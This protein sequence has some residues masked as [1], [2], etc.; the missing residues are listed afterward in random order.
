[1][2]HL[3]AVT[4]NHNSKHYDHLFLFIVDALRLDYLK[5]MKE[6]ENDVNG[7]NSP[8]N[9]FQFLHQLLTENSSQSDLF[10]FRADPPTVTSQRLK[11]LTTGSLPTFIDIAL[12]INS[13]S[14]KEDNLILQFQKLQKP[15]EVYGDDT[16]KLL[17]P[18][19]FSEYAMF[20]SFN[21]RDLSTVDEGILKKLGDFSSIKEGN[22]SLFVT[23]FLGVDHIGHTY[24]AFHPLMK[25]R[26]EIMDQTAKKIIGNLPENSLFLL[27]GDH[28]MTDGGEHGGSSYEELNSGLF[29]Y[30][31]RSFAACN[32]INSIKQ[33]GTSLERMMNP[34]VVQQIDIVPTIA[35]FFHFPIPFSSLGMIIP[36]LFNNTCTNGNR[37]YNEYLLRVLSSNANQ[38]WNYLNYYF[39]EK[40]F[41]D[42]DLLLFNNDSLSEKIQKLRNH[43]FQEVSSSSSNYHELSHLSFLYKAAVEN[44]LIF[45]EAKFVIGDKILANEEE[46]RK[47]INSY[48]SFLENVQ[49]DM[50]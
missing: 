28:G 16:W 22:W 26:L 11:G 8:Y 33:A 36:D 44:H 21:T 4:E 37:H 5:L 29:V 32:D 46:E 38:I 42:V 2:E 30:S 27:F 14:V 50:K 23:H 31:T 34:L 19:E 39:Y 15:M 47:V 25:E 20:D 12:N 17:F 1:L 7:D 24:N 41:I 40:T 35:S 48:I 13:S 43:L 49:N 9:R 3:L 10:A 18:T 6:N 45:L